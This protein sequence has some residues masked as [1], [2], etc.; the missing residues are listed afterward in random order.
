MYGSV[1]GLPIQS[2]EAAPDDGSSGVEAG[3]K[4]D[5]GAVFFVDQIPQRKRKLE[6]H[7]L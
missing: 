1:Y 2:G 5:P 4:L 7:Y 3:R 6:N